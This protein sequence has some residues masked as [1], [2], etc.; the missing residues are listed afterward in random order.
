MRDHSSPTVRTP[1]L[2]IVFQDSRRNSETLLSSL[3]HGLG[4]Y[5]AQ[6]DLEYL[7]AVFIR[8]VLPDTA[9]I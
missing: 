3:K 8:F 4:G 5:L 2:R 7:L 9:H 6:N 1:E